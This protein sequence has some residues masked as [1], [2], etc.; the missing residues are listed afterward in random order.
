MIID[1]ENMGLPACSVNL[2]NCH[3]HSI[4]TVFNGL[5]LVLWFA[6]SVSES[7]AD[8]GSCVVMQRLMW[9]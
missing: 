2:E 7:A 5:I 3:N 4:L 8:Y 6:F 9:C 1:M